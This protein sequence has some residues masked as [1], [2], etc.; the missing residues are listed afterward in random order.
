VP[1]ALVAGCRSGAPGFE[2]G[3]VAKLEGEI[4]LED[5]IVI[6]L[7][8]SGPVELIA[9]VESGAGEKTMRGP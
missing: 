2:D 3:V 4:D 7:G 8:R 6:E 1:V 9:L 5:A